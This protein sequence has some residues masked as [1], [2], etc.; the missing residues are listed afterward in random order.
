MLYDHAIDRPPETGMPTCP[1]WHALEHGEVY[2]PTPASRR[3][4]APDWLAYVDDGK[5]AP[6]PRTW[7]RDALKLGQMIERD[8]GHVERTTG[9][10]EYAVA[11]R[12]HSAVT[13]AS[14]RWDE[15]RSAINRKG[16]PA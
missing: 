2:P 11:E 5:P 9:W 10:C 3:A 4:A 14:R 16:A 7:F 1:T 8:T 12:V 15:Y 6:A 13:R